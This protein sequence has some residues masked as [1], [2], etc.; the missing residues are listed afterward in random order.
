MAARF[1]V[2]ISRDGS[3]PAA[4]GDW[5]LLRDPQRIERVRPDAGLAEYWERDD[6]G[7]VA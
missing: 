6:R 2:S 1:G 5:Y 3:R 4:Q 7:E